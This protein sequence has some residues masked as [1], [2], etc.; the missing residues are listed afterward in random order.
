MSQDS[1]PPASPDPN[2]PV[3]THTTQTEVLPTRTK[4]SWSSF[5]G[6]GFLV[7]LVL[8]LIL[9][10]VA[11]FWVISTFVDT[12]PEDPTTFATGAGGGTGGDRAKNFE[13]RIT[14]KNA[15]NM[16]K[17]PNKITVK[18]ATSSVALPDMPNLGM[19]AF[20]SGALMGG[21]SKGIGGGAGG[22]RELG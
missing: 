18:G 5:G 12:P 21:S 1:P 14:P 19:S 10:L 7:S 8:H 20:E 9:A 11:I 4:L 3:E 13:H 15:R 6:D 2:I 16:V 22:G 17:T